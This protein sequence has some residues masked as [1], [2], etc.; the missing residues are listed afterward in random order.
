MHDIRS[1]VIFQTV[2]R[3]I[4]RVL[5]TRRIYKREERNERAEDKR[6]GLLQVQ[7]ARRCVDHD[8]GGVISRPSKGRHEGNA[9]RE[10]ASAGAK[11]SQ[12]RNRS[13]RPCLA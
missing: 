12:G 11:I 4:A 3:W 10:D 2:L 1:S 8:L 5:S 7:C 6:G 13:S 9:T